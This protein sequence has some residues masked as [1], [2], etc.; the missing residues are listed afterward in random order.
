MNCP[1]CK[2]NFCKVIDSRITDNNSKRRRRECTGCGYRFSTYEL[3]DGK[4]M[5]KL[6]EFMKENFLDK[7]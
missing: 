7:E 6:Y 2:N 1:K 4:Q 3:I 5:H